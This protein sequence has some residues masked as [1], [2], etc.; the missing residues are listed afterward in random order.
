MTYKEC[1]KERLPECDN[2]IINYIVSHCCVRAVLDS[3]FKS[4][5]CHGYC[6]ACWDSEMKPRF[7]QE[8]TAK[9]LDKFNKLW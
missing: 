5:Y 2:D 1:L 9:I 7:P 6:N 3:S 4:K 8:I